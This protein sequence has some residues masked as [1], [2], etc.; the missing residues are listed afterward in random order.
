VP[1]F[2]QEKAR[3]AAPAK[4]PGLT[5]EQI[6]DKSIKATG[7]R[8]AMEKLVSTYAKGTMEFTAQETHG[9]MEFYAK[10]PNKQLAIMNLESVGEVRQG[11]D[12]QVAWGQDPTGQI[13]EISG[14]S[15]DDTK[16]RAV[17]NPSLKWRELYP[18]AE[19][20]GE[21]TVGDRKAYVVR[22]T[23][24]DGK[25]VTRYYDT[26]TFLLLR[27]KGTHETPQGPMDITADFSDYRDVGGVKAP[28]SIR[29][30][31]PVGEI[32]IN[33]SEMKNNIEIDDAKFSK[34]AK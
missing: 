21:D 4:K 12:G 22:L 16:R 34:P 6:I 29:Q 31:L 28:F 3:P 32:V 7:G 19:L 15:L 33:I 17:F 8:A 25:P 20:Q 18:K 24:T 27:E 14:A 5:A 9:V 23:A 2:A 30:S 11:F 1:G 10:A 26:E 13:I